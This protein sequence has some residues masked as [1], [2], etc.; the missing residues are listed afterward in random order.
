MERFGKTVV[1]SRIPILILSILLLIPA[2]FGYLNTRVNYD[3]LTYLPDEIETMKGQEILLDEFGTGAISMVVV[4]GMDFKDVAALKERIEGVDH[5]KKVIWYDTFLPLSVPTEVL[6]K[7]LRDAFINGEATLMAVTYDTGTSD[8]ETMQAITDIRALASKQCYV[9]GISGIVTDTRDLCN[10][11]EPVYVLVAVAL[12]FLVLSITMDTFLAPVFFLLSIGM[13]IVYNLGTN[14]FFG[15]IS[16]I[17]KALSAVLQLGVTMDYSIFLWNSYKE[18]Y[19]KT[20]DDREG[21]MARA[22]SMTLQSVVGSS[23]TTIAG[24]IALCFMSFTLG[25]DIGI[26]MSKG[27]L[28]GVIGCVTILPALILTFDKAIRRTAHKPLLP[29]IR[30]LPEFIAK[31]YKAVLLLFALIWIPAIWGYT[32]TS[33]YYQLDK[34]LPE[35]LPS[36]QANE[37]LSE[38]FDMG[39]THI[40]LIDRT[41]PEADIS[42]MVRDMEKVDG[43]KNILG[44]DA[45]IGGSV[46][47]ELLPEEITDAVLSEDYEMMLVGSAYQTASDEVNAQVDTLNRILKKYDPSGMLIGEAPCTRDLI[48]ITDHDFMV[49]NWASIGM[50][51]LIIF[52]VFRSIS[53]PALLVL[54]IEFAI[55]INMGIPGFTKTTLPFVASIVIG[56]VQLG[57]TVDYAILMTSRYQSERRAGKDKREAVITAHQMSTT[58]VIVSAFSFFAA[59][60]GVGLYSNISMISS[61]CILMAR[62]ALISMVTVLTVLPAVL[63]A[64]DPVIVRTS[65]GFLPEKETKKHTIRHET[66]PQG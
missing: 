26:V 3:V 8:D 38:S 15:E 37:K 56:T 52:F 2:A 34:S 9:A 4:D 66:Q 43:V 22:I 58:S 31:H 23:I 62:G 45:L 55:F 14:I 16:Y 17:T 21:A 7:E 13:C 44:I 33:V 6:P 40:L 39:A 36:V 60:I 46:P 47:R 25:L 35:D 49:V 10:R 27:V 53:L 57:S 28:F 24:F 61:L 32:H 29:E 12:A 20:P 48:R 11:E 51:F 42:N 64:A 59:T 54:V 41:T 50:I 1:K 30:R 18:N 19:L 65:R 63:L 5:V